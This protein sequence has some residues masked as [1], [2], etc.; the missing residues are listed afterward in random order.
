MWRNVPEEITACGEDT[1]VA[2]KS[3]SLDLDGEVGHQASL[4]E[5]PEHGQQ[6]ESV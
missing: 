6:L 4:A 1:A 2:G 3:V 5:R